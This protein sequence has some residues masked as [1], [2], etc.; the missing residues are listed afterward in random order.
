MR[1][2]LFSYRF[3]P[4]VGGV[5]QVSASLAAAWTEMGQS[6][7][8]V[9]TT[10]LEA[11]REDF[12][13]QFRYRV[14]RLAGEAKEIWK[15]VLAESDVVVSN[16]ASL[17]YLML[18]KRAGKPVVL[19]HTEVIWLA[20]SAGN[21]TLMEWLCRHA[22][23][24]LRRAI[25]RRAALNVFISKAIARNVAVPG[26]VVIYNPVDPMFSPRVDV[27]I[28]ADFGFFGRLVGHK[29]ADNLLDAL[30][31]CKSRGHIFTARLWGEG[32]E[33]ERYQGQARRMEIDRQVEFCA[34]V[35]G[36]ELV[37]A[38]NSVRV[39]V[40]PSKWEEPM[41]IVAVEAMACGKC[42]IGSSGGGLGEV[43]EGYC[44]TYPNGDVEQLAQRMIEA[45]TRE[46]CRR[47]CE[48]AALRRSGDFEAKHVAGE[49]LEQFRRC[50]AK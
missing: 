21:P 50:A 12:D 23:I 41:G 30:H 36:E 33:L 3:L 48:E 42:V 13:G 8:L 7:T 38:M 40:V 22:Q 43:L 4:L 26:G 6:V 46:D 11:G 18:W 2:C 19:I 15:A 16:G 9:T 32:D 31:L 14:V 39:V 27:P 47:Q 25:C 5:Q 10:P 34:F 37:R 45:M 1:I 28:A 44:P 24:R 29:G 49:Y 17:K 20:P 35:S